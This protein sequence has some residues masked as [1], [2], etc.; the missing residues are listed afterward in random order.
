MDALVQDIRQKLTDTG[1]FNWV[2]IWN[3]QIVRMKNL[4]EYAI[5][6]PSA[7]IEIS[8]PDFHQLG[9]EYQGIDIDMNIHIIS[10][11]LDSGD[12]DIDNQ[13]SIFGLRD[14]VV[15]AFSLYEASMG[16]FMVKTS[17][18]QDYNHTNLYHY[19]I[20]YKMH[21]IDDTAVEPKLTIS[22]VSLQ[23]PITITKPT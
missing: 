23:T 2:A 17:E 20:Q 9:E 16:G 22:G 21:Y 19:I 12:G 8:T 1:V 13:M 10:N 5:N 6:N 3:N 7:Y 18:T 4:T 14:A 11:E 15:R